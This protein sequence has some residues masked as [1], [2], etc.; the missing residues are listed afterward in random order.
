MSSSEKRSQS[1]SEP[2]N[3]LWPDY[4]RSYWPQKFRSQPVR[5]KTDTLALLHWREEVSGLPEKYTP[6]P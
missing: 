5:T 4:F 6:I 3:L 1:P 2:G